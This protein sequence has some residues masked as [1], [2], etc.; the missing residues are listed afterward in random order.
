MAGDD[1]NVATNHVAIKLPQFWTNDPESWFLQAEAMFRRAKVQEESTR[2]DHVLAMLPCEVI[3]SVRDI[4][5]EPDSTR[6]Y[7]CLK[8][9]L[10]GSYTTPTWQALWLSLIHI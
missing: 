1:H 6:P 10:L 4:I 5:K 3:A 2:F 7:S 8:E 9:R